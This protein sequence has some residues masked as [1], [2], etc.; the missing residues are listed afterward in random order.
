[1]YGYASF[2]AIAACFFS[3]FFFSFFS[4][5]GS[6]F[7]GSLRPTQTP[8]RK[9]FPLRGRSYDL[10]IYRGVCS[11]GLRSRYG[12][13]PKRGRTAD[14]SVTAGTNECCNLSSEKMTPKRKNQNKNAGNFWLGECFTDIRCRYS[15]KTRLFNIGRGH[16][17]ACDK[18]RT[19]ILAGSNLMSNWRTENKDIWQANSDSIDGYKQ[20]D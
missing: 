18:C 20:I 4:F 15:H 17:V 3:L 19:Y 1:M 10:K 7:L 11:R 5:F 13:L 16:Y 9:S 12:G 6:C 8:Y 2:A 14:N